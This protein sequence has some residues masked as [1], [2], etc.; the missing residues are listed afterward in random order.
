MVFPLDGWILELFEEASE[1]RNLGKIEWLATDDPS[2]SSMSSRPIAAFVLRGA[3]STKHDPRFRFSTA[4][5]F[6]HTKSLVE[7]FRPLSFSA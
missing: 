5:P 7:H 4:C 2:Q 6:G 3:T 1:V